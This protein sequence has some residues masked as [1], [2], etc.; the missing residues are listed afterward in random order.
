MVLWQ[1]SRSCR[2]RPYVSTRRPVRRSRWRV[3]LAEEEGHLRALPD[4]DGPWPIGALESNPPREEP[5]HLALGDGKRRAGGAATHGE[6][7]REERVAWLE[8]RAHGPDVLGAARGIDGREAR[9]RPDAVERALMVAAEHE[10]VAFDERGGNAVGIRQRARLGD[11]GGREIEADRRVAVS[12]E[13]PHVVAAPAARHCDA[14]WRRR[15][16]LDELDERRRRLAKL[17]PVTPTHVEIGP[18]LGRAHAGHVTPSKCSTARSAPA[19]RSSVSLWAVL[20]PMTRI[21]A[22]RAACTP[23]TASSNTRQYAG[24]S[25][26][27]RAASR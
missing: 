6:E 9:V 20:T 18:E 4:P 27:P 1:A 25:P 24:G 10:D 8:N 26:R 22:L 2:R 15:C 5:P 21:P 19:A 11:R 7:A 3:D 13:I 16:P 14:S 17:P 12:S 23:T